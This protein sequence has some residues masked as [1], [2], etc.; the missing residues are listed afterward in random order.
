MGD[1]GLNTRV[2]NTKCECTLRVPKSGQTETHPLA[3]HAGWM[4]YGQ[5]TFSRC[6]LIIWL[7]M[8]VSYVQT[9]HMHR[10]TQVPYLLTYLHSNHLHYLLT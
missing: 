4:M 5:K 10:N 2:P 7:T 1:K 6:I 3:H 9:I 8:V